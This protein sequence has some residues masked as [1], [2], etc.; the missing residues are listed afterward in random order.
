[1]DNF[2]AAKPAGEGLSPAIEL[3]RRATEEAVN[4]AMEDQ[5]LSFLEDCL[6]DAETPRNGHYERKVLTTVGEITVRVPRD[7]LGLFRER[8]IG[9]HRRRI[10]DLD[11]EIGRLYSQ[12]LSASDISRYLSARSGVEG[13]EKLI[14]AIVKGSYGEAERFNSRALPRC[15]FVYL[16]GTWLPV[17]RRYE[18]FGYSL[19]YLNIGFSLLIKTACFPNRHHI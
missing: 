18:D 8:V 2:N 3:M 1:M 12:G 15:P 7:R 11:W 13:S 9:R 17:R 14:L 4:E 6:S 10:D 5:F 16:D 19:L